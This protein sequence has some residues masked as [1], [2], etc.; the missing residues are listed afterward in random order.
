MSLKDWKS[1]PKFG[2]LNVKKRR[3]SKLS[4]VVLSLNKL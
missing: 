1:T 2:E 4:F 3:E